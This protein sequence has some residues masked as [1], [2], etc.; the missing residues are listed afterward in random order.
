MDEFC[1]T[2]IYM[3]PQILKNEPYTA[4]C[5]IWSLGLLLYEMLYGSTPWPLRCL[6][7]YIKAIERRPLSFPFDVKVGK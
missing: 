4:K 2:P 5:D 7:T 6:A 1:G 3:A